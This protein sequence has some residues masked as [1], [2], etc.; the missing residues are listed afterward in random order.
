[1][2]A[3]VKRVYGLAEDSLNGITDAIRTDE[4]I[5]WIHVPHEETAAF[6]AGAENRELGGVCRELWPWKSAFD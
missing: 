3:G 2:A 6:A 1:V 4:R 5:K